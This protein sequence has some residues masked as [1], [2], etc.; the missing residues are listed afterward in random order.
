M[1]DFASYGWALAAVA[2]YAVMAQV[3]NVATGMK[4]RA[5]KMSLG[6]TH[7]PD[8]SDPAYRLDRT[9]THSI[10]LMVFFAALVLTSIMA[11][12]D[13]LYVN[14][15]AVLGL[16]LRVASNVIYLGG[17]SVD[18][19]KFRTGLSIGSAA[20]NICLAILTF[21]AAVWYQS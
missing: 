17:M 11:G 20:V 13:P 1:Q 14:V 4:K 12:A 19:S 5:L 7:A 9:Y 21:A 3:L 10:E 18:H 16:L 15:L 6:D 2:L 8:A